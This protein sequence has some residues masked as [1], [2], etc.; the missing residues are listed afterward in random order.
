[1]ALI[2]RNILQLQRTTPTLSGGFNLPTVLGQD[3]R[4]ATVSYE[5]EF[6]VL[7]QPKIAPKSLEFK[8]TL[9]LDLTK[10]TVT[11]KTL[12]GVPIGAI[13]PSKIYDPDV[14][15]PEQFIGGAYL[16]PVAIETLS[17]VK[18]EFAVVFKVE[19]EFTMP[20]I[21]SPSFDPLG[22]KRSTQAESRLSLLAQKVALRSPFLGSRVA[23]KISFRF[24]R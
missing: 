22:L 16:R 8:S 10:P 20:E 11:A 4:R 7:Q 5:T 13:Y 17:K 12:S 18:Q 19:G 3:I 15:Q 24:T 14:Y 21:A 6:G 23:P 1:M 9:S 2:R